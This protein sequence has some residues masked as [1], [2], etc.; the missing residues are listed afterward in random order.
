[1]TEGEPGLV[2]DCKCAPAIL[3]AL[4]G[5]GLAV[6]ELGAALEVEGELG[7]IVVGLPGIGDEALK[8]LAS[9]S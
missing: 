4:G 5:N 8:P 9:K 1:M 6:M 7:G 2:S 3:E